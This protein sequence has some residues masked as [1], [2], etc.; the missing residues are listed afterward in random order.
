MKEEQNEQKFLGKIMNKTQQKHYDKTN[1]ILEKFGAKIK[2]GESYV[3]SDNQIMVTNKYN[4]DKKI[5]ANTIKYLNPDNDFWSFD[6]IMSDR[7]RN[8]LQIIKK[9]AELKG[10]NLLST[11]YIHSEEK[12]EFEDKEGNRFFMSISNIKNN[13]W[14]GYE[15]GN[16]Y[17]NPEYHLEILRKIAESKGGKL[18]SN[19]YTKAHDKLEFEDKKGNRFF[20][21]ATNVKKN[22]WSGYESGNV[23]N[24]PEYHLNILRKI[25]ES[26]NGKLISTKYEGIRKKLEFEDRLKN[27]FW[28]LPNNVKKGKWSPFEQANTSEEKCRQCFEFLFDKD[29]VNTWDV[30]TKNG[31]RYLQLDG[32]NKELKLA[33][34]Y[35]GEQHYNFNAIPGGTLE[36]KQK[37]FIKIQKND[38]IKE[39]LCKENKIILFTIKYFD[40]F[41]TDVDFL[42]HVI[43]EI[44]KYKNEILNQFLNKNKDIFKF[45]YQ[46]FPTN[47][48]YI[49]ELAEISKNRGGK[50]ISTKYID[51]KTKL[52]F[53]DKYGIR[54][55]MSSTNIRKG[56]WSN[57][58]KQFNHLKIV[59]ELAQKKGFKL[60]SNKYISTSNLLEFENDK[61]EKFF[62]TANYVKSKWK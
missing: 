36:N 34:E 13:R 22:R 31:K 61:G 39:E 45:N 58:E 30:L 59:S 51:C 24:N 48:K 41:K 18:I 35:Q 47:Q 23:Y 25:A 20:M 52:E 12:L 29:F 7:H 40:N 17:N 6:G 53:E 54:F 50:L 2:D 5:I 55:F 44:K 57:S 21:S 56:N 37:R 8:E 32:Y 15:S 26:K 33:F 46:Q 1:K 27:R 60:I 38:K 11:I 3:H 16:V 4:I 9:I 42:N 14:S 62:K 10:G 49:N 28:S 43:N 19:K